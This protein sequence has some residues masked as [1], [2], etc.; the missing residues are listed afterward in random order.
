MNTRE[1][2]DTG[3]GED[4]GGRPMVEGAGPPVRQFGLLRLRRF[5][6]LFWTQLLGAFNDNVFKQ[7]VIIFITFRLLG[8]SSADDASAETAR[9]VTISA[10]VFILPFALLSASAGQI[11]DKYDKATLFRWVKAAEVVIMCGAAAAFLL[12][13]M[14]LLLILL[15][16][17]G[18]QSTFFGPLKYATLPQHLWR[19]ELVGGNGLIQMSTYVAILVGTLA[20]GVAMDL[21]GPVPVA[22]AVVMVA[23]AGLTTS[24]FVPSAPP[25]SP[26]LRVDPNIVRQSLRVIGRARRDATVFAAIVGISWFWFLGATFV[27]VIPAYGR[28]VLGGQPSVVNLIMAAF[29]TGIGIGSLLCET[30]VRSRRSIGLVPAGALGL[31]LL[32]FGAVLFGPDTSAHAPASRGAAQVL[33]DPSSWLVLFGFMGFALCGGL[34]IVPLYAHLQARSDPLYRARIIAANNVLNAVLMVL[35]GVMTL[36][37]L[38]LAVPLSWIFAVAGLLTIPV[39]GLILLRAPAL[40]H[41]GR[42][43][44]APEP[45]ARPSDTA[46]TVTRK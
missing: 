15:F 27:Q 3:A 38:R 21:L 8:Q 18:A 45:A 25:P 30:L 5:A 12:E 43:L 26:Q 20:G 2:A 19:S 39:V 33:A 7:A 17:M 28:D 11:A 36:V 41:A 13:S 16:L 6:P 10:L 29:S 44:R 35:S 32:S 9:M 1:P 14:P 34:Y 4:A 31:V 46:A 37:L 40:R 22:V 42:A 24:Q 23:L